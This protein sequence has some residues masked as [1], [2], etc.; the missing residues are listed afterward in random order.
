MNDLEINNHAASYATPRPSAMVSWSAEAVPIESAGQ[1]ALESF[2]GRGGYATST[3]IAWRARAV[4]AEEPRDDVWWYH[5]LPPKTQ[6]ALHAHA[7]LPPITD[8]L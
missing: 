7:R 2:A 1:H 6:T 8:R 3:P 4:R 5:L